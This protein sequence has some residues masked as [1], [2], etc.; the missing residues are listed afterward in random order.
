MVDGDQVNCKVQWSANRPLLTH[1]TLCLIEPCKS[2]FQPTRSPVDRARSAQLLKAA[3][4]LHATLRD[5]LLCV[6]A[7][8]AASRRDRSPDDQTSQITQIP[9][10]TSQPPSDTPAAASPGAVCSDRDCP[11]SPDSQQRRRQ[12]QLRQRQKQ[13]RARAAQRLVQAID[14]WCLEQEA[15]IQQLITAPA[16]TN[17][18]GSAGIPPTDSSSTDRVTSPD[19][20]PSPSAACSTLAS[21]PPAKDPSAAARIDPCTLARRF[22]ECRRAAVKA[23]LDDC[24]A[25]S[26]Q[27]PQQVNGKFD[28]LLTVVRHLRAVE[29]DLAFHSR[30]ARAAA[31][32]ADKRGCRDDASFAYGSTSFSSWLQVRGRERV[33]FRPCISR[34]DSLAKG[35]SPTV[36]SLMLCPGLVVG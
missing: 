34:N 19:P 27:L 31:A 28:Q 35:F 12:Q 10:Q 23:E 11:P 17:Q 22:Q 18:P 1:A 21:G 29:G 25:A 20:S 26:Q 14:S 7:C 13:Q 30:L 32:A 5:R 2:P 9:M 3:G 36:E 16:T 33:C 4:T 15:F 8:E 6:P 24:A